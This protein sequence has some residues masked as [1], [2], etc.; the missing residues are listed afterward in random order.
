MITLKQTVDNYKLIPLPLPTKYRN[1]LEAL[2]SNER[3]TLGI[4]G[5][6]G[7]GK[8]SWLLEFSAIL[9]KFGNVLYANFE[10]NIENGTIQLKIQNMGILE[11]YP[12]SKNKVFF[13]NKVDFQQLKIYLKT[14]KF[15]FCIIDSVSKLTDSKRATIEE[16]LNLLNEFKD[17]NFIFVYHYTKD[18]KGYKGSSAYIHEHDIMID[19]EKGG[20]ASFK[21]NR[22]K[23]NKTKYFNYYHIFNK[24]LM[25]E[26]PINYGERNGIF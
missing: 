22:Y 23:T 15:K 11:N 2:P 8:S 21:K 17:V 9:S 24:K 7:A 18:S 1:W 3:W 6:A 13:L 14:N 12:Y 16:I 19:I 5:Q 20:L 10:E 26:K 4:S 25:S